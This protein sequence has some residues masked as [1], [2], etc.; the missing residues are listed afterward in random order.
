MSFE[1]DADYE[2]LLLYVDPAYPTKPEL[3]TVTQKEKRDA[4]VSN[5]LASRLVASAE[6][7]LCAS[8]AVCLSKQKD[9]KAEKDLVFFCFLCQRSSLRCSSIGLRG[10][11][12]VQK[13]C[14]QF[15]INLDT[16]FF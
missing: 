14:L 1:I 15:I 6:Q 16:E 8:L 11:A 4:W 2:K 12:P 10:S 9:Q 3:Q 13:V 5:S 7:S